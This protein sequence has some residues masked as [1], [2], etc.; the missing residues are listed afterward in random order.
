MM[1]IV[2]TVLQTATTLGSTALQAVMAIWQSMAAMEAAQKGAETSK[3]TAAV[4]Q[5]SA[6]TSV[7]VTSAA[8]SVFQGAGLMAGVIAKFV[9]SATAA[10]PFLATGAGQVFLVG[11][12]TETIAEALAV[13]AKT[14]GELSVHSAAMTETGTKVP[15]TNAPSNVDPSQAMSQIMQILGPLS[16]LAGSLPQQVSSIHQA[17]A[18]PKPVVT[19]DREDAE[20]LSRDGLA[21]G[22]G[23]GGGGMVGGVG[24]G[25]AAG[26]VRQLTPWGGA[27]TAGGLGSAGTNAGAGQPVAPGAS[28]GPRGGMM[29]PGA[30]MMPMG[31][32]AAG[33]ARG[34]E[35]TADGLR[36]QLVTEEH[37]N[38]VVGEI[39]GASLPVVGA[40][41]RVTEVPGTEPPDKALTL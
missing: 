37:G 15:V 7:G 10:A 41:E 40:V 1:Q 35:S 5:Q 19:P 38:E 21:G 8:G 17:L 28:S 20:K 6:Q 23:G 12:T 11:L 16:Q 31:A 14:R 29:S 36:G 22:G 9:A 30:G 25:G 13:V 27:N 3:D 32:G 24:G 18:P 39:E 4:A 26:A 33:M 2:S 34:A